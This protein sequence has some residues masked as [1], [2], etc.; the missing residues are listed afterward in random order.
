MK[1]TLNDARLMQGEHHADSLHL[2]AGSLPENAEVRVA[3]LTPR[4]R[5]C[6]SPA[7]TL[8]NG[9]GDFSLPQSLLDGAGRLLA[10]LLAETDERLLK[11]EVFA[12]DVEKSIDA[13]GETPEDGFYTLSGACGRL[14]ALAFD[15]AAFMD[16]TETALAGKQAALTFDETPTADS[17]NPVTSGGVKAYVDAAAAAAVPNLTDYAKKSYVDSTAEMKIEERIEQGIDYGYITGKTTVDSTPT[18]NS[19]HLVTSGGVK[20]YVDDAVADVDVDLTD[21]YTKDEV[22]ARIVDR[23]VIIDKTVADTDKTTSG[24]INTYTWEAAAAA[25][26][27]DLCDALKHILFVYDNTARSMASVGTSPNFA[28]VYNFPDESSMTPTGT[29]C[30]RLRWS[31]SGGVSYYHLDTDQE[32]EGDFEFRRDNPAC[33]RDDLF[34]PH[35]RSKIF[36]EILTFDNVPTAGSDNPVKSGGVK[37][38]VEAQGYVNQLGLETTLMTALLAYQKKAELARV[39]S[40]GSYGDL[41]DTPTVDSTPTANSTHLVTSGGVKTYVDTAVAGA[42]APTRVQVAFSWD[43][44]KEQ[45]TI[46]SVTGDIAGAFAHAMNG[47]S[48]LVYADLAEGYSG[49]TV[50]LPLVGTTITQTQMLL[51]FTTAAVS[52]LAAVILSLTAESAAAAPTDGRFYFTPAQMEDMGLPAVYLVFD[53]RTKTLN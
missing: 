27:L 33:R 40:T 11:S 10:Q 12:F 42:V 1:I 36:Q 14:D 15:L 51:T 52:G 34:W 18:A 53:L 49:G 5:R 6:E 44:T 41:T 8:V 20:A 30:F 13:T 2:S 38:Y 16:E 19:T 7:V 23:D 31:E 43:I 24:G 28:L 37:S 29:P 4:G 35:G 46:D 50:S 47:R 25:E 48:D 22:V 17:R 32:L 3:F 26:T 39:A 21:Y 9:E 45:Q